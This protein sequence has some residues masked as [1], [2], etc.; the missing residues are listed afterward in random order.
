MILFSSSSWLRVSFGGPCA[1]FIQ[2]GPIGINIGDRPCRT[3]RG[4]GRIASAQIALHYFSGIVVVVNRAKRTGD[5][6]DFATNTDI[7]QY[8]FGPCAVIQ[9]NGIYRT[10]LQTPGFSALGAGIR[11]LAAF[12]MK[13]KNFDA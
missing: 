8:D 1:H 6:A 4:T 13:F 2:T 12:M 3:G 11:N 9:L 5:G 7:I 10:S